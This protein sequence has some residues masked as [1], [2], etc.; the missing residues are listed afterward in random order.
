MKKVK[1][2]FISNSFGDDTIQY[3]PEIAHDFDYDLDLYNL[4]IGGCDINKHIYNIKNNEKAYELRIY[5]KDKKEWE[6]RID[7]SVNDFIITDKWDFIVL[8]QSSYFSGLPNGL[9]NIE[10]LLELVKSLAN[11]STKYVWNMTWSYPKYSDLEIFKEAFDCNQ[12]KMHNAIVE[13][14]KEKIVLN[15]DFVKIIPNAKAIY[16]AREEL[17]DELIHRDGFHLSYQPGRYLAGLTA[18]ATLLDVDI[19]EVKFYPSPVSEHMKNV[20]TGC[21]EDAIEEPFII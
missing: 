17:G 16:L 10:V 1:I 8:Q 21:V 3:M 20:F 7:V 9:E 6:T 18:I 11:K 12:E 14:V 13:N 19:S 2:L 4:F 5:N 15:K